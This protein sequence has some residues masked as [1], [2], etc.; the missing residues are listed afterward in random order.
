MLYAMFIAATKLD[1]GIAGA[2][3][4]LVV[5]QQVP[6]HLSCRVTASGSTRRELISPSNKKGSCSARTPDFPRAIVAPDEQ[7]A[8]FKPELLILILEEI[9]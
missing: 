8:F 4:E 3:L 1:P 6:G 7:P 5:H 9:Q 2:V